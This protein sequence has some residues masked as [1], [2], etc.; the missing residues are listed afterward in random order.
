MGIGK[1]FI[2]I[3]FG[4]CESR[5]RPIFLACGLN[6][7]TSMCVSITRLPTHGLYTVF[8]IKI[9]EYTTHHTPR[10]MRARIYIPINI[11]IKL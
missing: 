3:P 11:H 1:L 10:Y 7:Q 2:Y 8:F 4:N 6:A 5:N 9:F